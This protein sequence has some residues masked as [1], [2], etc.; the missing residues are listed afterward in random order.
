MNEAT[1][2][3]MTGFL[4]LC[5]RAGQPVSG[6]EACVD[7]IRRGTA[8]LAL[9]DAGASENTRKRVQDACKAHD[10]PL[11]ELSAGALGNCIGKH[12]RMVITL[13]AGGMANK[14]KGLLE[15]EPRLL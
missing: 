9:L 6:Q 3:Q 7:A 4:G 13:P 1:E 2:T 10:V 8:V 11:Y 15:N 14:L 12:G 5:M